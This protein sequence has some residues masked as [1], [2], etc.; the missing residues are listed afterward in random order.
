MLLIP[1][2]KTEKRTVIP[3]V[4]HVDGSARVQTVHKELNPEFYRLIE[5]FYNITGIPLL[6]NTSFNRKGEPI[7]ET[8]TDA[9]KTFLSHE[10]DILFLNGRIFRKK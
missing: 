1:F 6:L 10:I 3:A 7:V 9:I 5:C 2:V 8:P 4:T